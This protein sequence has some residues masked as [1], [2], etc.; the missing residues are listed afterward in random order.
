[1]NKIIVLA[2]VTAII[3]L[4]ANALDV[5]GVMSTSAGLLTSSEKR[6]QN[7]GCNK[8]A[9]KIIEDGQDYHLSG[10]LTI[11]LEAE[12]K[13]VQA[14]QLD[15]SVDEVVDALTEYATLLINDLK[16]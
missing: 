14:E 5:I 3:S 1:M 6:C 9:I 16:E 12:V 4:Q 11:F 10:N 2:I 15:M 13:K 7:G 8:E